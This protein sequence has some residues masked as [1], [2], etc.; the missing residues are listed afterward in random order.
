MP[1]NRKQKKKKYERER[2]KKRVSTGEKCIVATHY[3]AFEM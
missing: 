3:Y 1:D 2:E